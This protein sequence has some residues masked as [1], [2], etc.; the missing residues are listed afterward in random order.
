MESG[1]FIFITGLAASGK[2]RLAKKVYETLKPKCPSI[3][4][5]DG[6]DLRN[7]WGVWGVKDTSGRRKLAMSYAKTCKYL[8]D[9][10]VDVILSS[11]SL[12]HDVQDY[13][14]KNNPNYYEILLQVD[15][16]VLRKRHE[17]K[18]PHN[19][20]KQRWVPSTAEFPKNP[21]LVLE[22][23]SKGQIE[24]NVERILNLIK[25]EK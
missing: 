21:D 19:T 25:I 23:N 11:V 8:A 5:I 2:T 10:G 1:K 3:I 16:S 14:R 12:F 20:Q 24:E 15:E 18:T 6:D 13:N 9:Q 22:N 7:I 17:E 4:Y